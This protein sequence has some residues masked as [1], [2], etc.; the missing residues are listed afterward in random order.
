MELTLWNSFKRMLFDP[1]NTLLT[2][3]I[4]FSF[5]LSSYQRGKFIIYMST[6]YCM[7]ELTQHCLPSNIYIYI[8]MYITQFTSYS[9]PVHL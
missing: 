7:K 9:H 1:G 2:L 8:Y 6:A 5:V 3:M 4:F